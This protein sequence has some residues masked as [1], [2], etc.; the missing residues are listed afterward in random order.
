MSKSTP[1]IKRKGCF[2]SSAVSDLC[3]KG[4]GNLTIENVGKPFTTYVEEKVFERLLNRQLNKEHSA[5]P[6]SWGK[7]VEEYAFNKLGLEYS[8]VSKERFSHEV[9]GDYWNG[10]PDLITDEIVGDIKCPYTIKSFCNLVK[11]M[12]AGPEALKASHPSYYW[13]LVSNAI[14]CKKDKAMLVIYVPYLED[15]EGIRDLAREHLGDLNNQFAFIN[16]SEDEELPYIV[17]DGYYSDLHSMEFEIPKE[18][19]EFLEARVVM[20]I[21]ELETQ[22][23]EY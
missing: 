4:R 21:S 1:E 12:N 10:M 9:Y 7:L 23:K 2:S 13:Q 11:S 15:L 8:L 19:K 17:K 3:S 14:L 6:T 18:D 5:R 20:A 16:W 22:L